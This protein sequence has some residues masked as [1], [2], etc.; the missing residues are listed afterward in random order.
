MMRAFA[1]VA[2]LAVFGA[3]GSSSGAGG[4]DGGDPDASVSARGF[5][6]TT[7]DV[8]IHA[9]EEITYCYYFKTSNTE[10]LSIKKWASTW[11]AG[12]HHVILYFTSS[13]SKPE[14]TMDPDSCGFGSTGINNLPSWIYS[15]QSS[16]SELVLPADDGNGTPVGMDVPA[17]QSAMLEVHY[18]NTGDDDV[19][20]HATVN[21]EAYDAGVAITKTFAYVTY[22]AGFT[23]PG[24][25]G[26]SGYA[27]TNTCPIP[28]S[29][30]VWLMS[31]HAH[32]HAIHTEVRNGD[33]TSTDIV[34]SSDDWEHPGAKRMDN[35][36]YQFATGQ[37]TNECIYDNHTGIEVT[38]G[39]SA[40]TNEMCMASGYTFPATKA[41]FCVNGYAL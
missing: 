30:K 28:S 26:G 13:L 40:K 16:P 39:S 35:P 8:T 11:T 33:D 24:E 18:N 4:D 27:V 1:V 34:F 21:A 36:F 12:S 19:I 32:K 23:V 7:P 5:E 14:G 6:V 22:L 3:C 29:S 10:A 17:G 37:L 20:S 15:A 2:S 41:T 9:H 25:T 31:T 38:E